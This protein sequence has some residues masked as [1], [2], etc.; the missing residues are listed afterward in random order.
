[1]PTSALGMDDLAI[2]L[3]ALSSC[4]L[5]MGVASCTKS[6]SP[7]FKKEKERDEALETKQV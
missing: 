2:R 1:M 3:R 6:N 7:I 4:S 5:T